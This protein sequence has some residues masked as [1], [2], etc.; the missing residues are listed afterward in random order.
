MRRLLSVGPC[1]EISHPLQQTLVVARVMLEADDKAL[2]SRLLSYFPLSVALGKELPSMVGTHTVV[3]IADRL[4]SGHGTRLEFVRHEE[5]PKGQVVDRV[6]VVRVKNGLFSSESAKDQLTV[7]D[8]LD[9]GSQI[10]L[11]GFLTYHPHPQKPV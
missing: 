2:A 7:R 6:V 3:E 4:L 9:P 10:D 5:R 8:C 1:K 11:Q